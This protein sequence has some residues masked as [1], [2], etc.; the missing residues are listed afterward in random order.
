M[1]VGYHPNPSGSFV[2]R[3]FTEDETFDLFE[4]YLAEKAEEAK[5]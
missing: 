5:S 2:V 4:R 1:R 3:E